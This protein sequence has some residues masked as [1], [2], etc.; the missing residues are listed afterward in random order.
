MLFQPCNPMLAYDAQLENLNPEEVVLEPKEDGIRVQVHKSD[1]TVRLFSRSCMDITNSFPALIESVKS[2]VNG[3]CIID[4]E[5]IGG[6]NFRTIRKNPQLRIFDMLYL[7]GENMTGMELCERRNILLGCIGANLPN[8]SIIEQFKP[9]TLLD[10][11]KFYIG[12][13][14]KG[15]E[16]IMIKKLDSK[17]SDGRSSGWLKLKPKATLDLAVVEATY[18]VPPYDKLL[19]QFVLACKDEHGKLLKFCKVFAGLTF[20]QR[21]ELTKYLETKI[22]ERR[23]DSVAL[24]PEI[25]FEINC[26]G[27]EKSGKWDLPFIPRAASIVKIRWD[28]TINEIDAKE[29]VMK[30]AEWFQV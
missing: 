24:N 13:V 7:D 14:A 5:I 16:G 21:I 15:F 29:K 25:V 12:C 2:N 20:L 4:G 6:K 10:I 17:Y 19:S 1:E 26:R 23:A 27:F 18:G 30:Y 8:F 9:E 28:K 3:S 22:L 11:K